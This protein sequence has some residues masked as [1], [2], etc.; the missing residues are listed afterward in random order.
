MGITLPPK[1]G[2]VSPSQYGLLRD[3]E[4]TTISSRNEVMIKG[5]VNSSQDGVVIDVDGIAPTHTSGHGNTPKI[6]DRS[7]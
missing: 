5:R 6:L 4:L 2:G 1:D 7:H 3:K